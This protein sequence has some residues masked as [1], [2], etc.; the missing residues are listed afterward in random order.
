LRRITEYVQAFLTRPLSLEELARQVGFS[1]YHFAR[2]FRQAVGE[3]PHQFVLRQRV[4]YAK[5]LLR[6]PDLPIS[7]VAMA[8]GFADQS[9]L[10]QIFKRYTGMTPRAF[11]ITT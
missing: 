1:P 7:Q 2:L 8:S 11:R 3:S 10:T 9:H 5:Q 6:N 4:D